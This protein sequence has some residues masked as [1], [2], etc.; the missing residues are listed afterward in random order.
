MAKLNGIFAISLDFELYWGMRDKSTV[1]DYEPNLKGV[2]EAIERMLEL[3]EKYNIHVTWATV[4]FLFAKDIEELI[5]AFPKKKP[6]YYNINLNPYEYIKNSDDL[7]N[8]YHFAPELVKKISNYNN[9]EIGSH[10]FS[11]YYC[12]ENGQTIKDF[13]SDIEAVVSIAKKNNILIKSLVFPRNQWNNEYLSILKE[14]GITSY[15][16][17]QKGWLFQ[18]T[19]ESDEKLTRRALRLIDS[20]INLS[21]AN[22]YS[23]DS[24]ETFKPYDIPAS[25]YLRPV[26][27]IFSKLENIRLKRITNSLKQAAKNGEIFHLWWHPHDFG[28]NM[29][30]NINF[31]DALFSSFVKLRESYGITSLNMGEISNLICEKDMD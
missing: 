13:Y 3:F 24:I 5:A 10:T 6:Q 18:A 19:K 27:K 17:N 30:D 23:L 20:Y 26:S 22:S 7:N 2:E 15:R 14:H 25:C 4:G 21:G 31:L 12:L 8:H 16:G 9:Q 29:D 28:V 11:H 1:Y